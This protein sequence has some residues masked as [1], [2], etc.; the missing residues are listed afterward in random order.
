MRSLHVIVLCVALGF[1]ACQ[2]KVVETQS[3]VTSSDASNT[4][5]NSS[6][7]K[8]LP[9]Q[10]APNP[11]FQPILS[12]LENKT[13]IAVSVPK[14]IPE[15]NEPNPIY[16]LVEKI[17]PSTYQ[18]LLAFTEDCTGGTACR[19]GSISGEAISSKNPVLNGEKVFLASNITGYFTDAMCGANCSDSTLVWEQNDVRYTVAL[20]AGKLETLVKIAN[21][22]I[23]I[24][25]TEID[26][27]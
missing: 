23:S 1:S 22:A 13:K 3:E 10:S 7:V 24:Q 20:K 26:P 8:T 2:T 6:R 16:A 19:L 18:I 9:K 21:S 15:S 11:I 12:D 17:T 25:P 14:Y 4:P 27:S 5:I